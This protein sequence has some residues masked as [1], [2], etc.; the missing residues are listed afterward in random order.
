MIA[1]QGGIGAYPLL[2]GQI[3]LHYGIAEAHGLAFGWVS[4]T[5]QTGVVVV[6]GVLSLILLPIYNNRKATHA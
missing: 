2:V 3:L 1:T 6:F 5:V 4:W